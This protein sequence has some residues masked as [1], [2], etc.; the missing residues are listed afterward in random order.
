MPRPAHLVSFSP[1]TAVIKHTI[2]ETA[3]AAITSVSV[4]Y[5]SETLQMNSTE[6][7]VFFLATLLCTLPGTQLG[8]WVTRRCGN[9][10]NRS[11][12]MSMVALLVVLI[13][14]AVVLDELPPQYR[15]F[16]YLWGACVGT[17]LGWF[18]PTENLFFSMCL[19]KGREAEL[20]GFFVYCTQI[21]GWLP[22]LLFT[23]LV[24]ADVHQKY[25]V[26]VTS[27]GFL[28]AVGLLSMTAPWDEIV[29]EAKSCPGDLIGESG[30]QAVGVG[31]KGTE[32]AEP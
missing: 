17:C 29:L 15:N 22:P 13:V 20:A 8:A 21:L 30:S 12:K 24:E 7:G 14:G 31:T 5:L 32:Q 25:G 26:I 27:F 11:W 9:D 3:A 4:V 18:Y 28:V 1:S 23:L 10:P 6:I 2:H 19:P 16:S